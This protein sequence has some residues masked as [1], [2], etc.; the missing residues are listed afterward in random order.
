MRVKPIRTKTSRRVTHL[1][2]DES[3][4]WFFETLKSEHNNERVTVRGC[5]KAHE[6]KLHG[7]M[8]LRP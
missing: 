1:E 8:K 6:R 2:R 5:E 3:G 7:S 4:S